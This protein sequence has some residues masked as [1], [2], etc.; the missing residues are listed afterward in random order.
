MA[1]IKIPVE[2]KKYASVFGKGMVAQFAPEVLKGGLVEVMRKKT[3]EATCN[4][5][6]KNIRLWNELEPDH[7]KS[8]LKLGEVVKDLSWLTADWFIEVI[9]KDCPALAS[10]FLGWEKAYNWLERQI[11][12]IKEE[13]KK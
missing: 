7:R 13:I 11:E 3:V 9:K 12:I 5:V 2:V 6:D 1:Q 8:L 10:L 4:W